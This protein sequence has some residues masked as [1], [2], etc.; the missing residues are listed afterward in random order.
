MVI[1]FG[2]AFVQWIWNLDYNIPPRIFIFNIYSFI[3]KSSIYKTCKKER[4]FEYFA[5]IIIKLTYKHTKKYI[6]FLL[7]FLHTKKIV[8]VFGRIRY[9]KIHREFPLV[10]QLN[11]WKKYYTNNILLLWCMF[12]KNKKSSQQDLVR[13]IN[14]KNQYPF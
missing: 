6:V 1:F 9:C 5:N 4:L 7:H 10:Q 8:I 12:L 11:C 2:H 13:K 14:K 3:F